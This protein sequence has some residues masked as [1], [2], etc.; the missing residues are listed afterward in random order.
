MD[1]HWHILFKEIGERGITKFMRKL[2]TA[3]TMYFNEQYNRVG[4]LF[5]GTFKAEHVNDDSY[6]QYIYAH[7][8]ESS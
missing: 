6:L 5:Q 3:Y 1:N 2:T 8:L 4:P 7:T